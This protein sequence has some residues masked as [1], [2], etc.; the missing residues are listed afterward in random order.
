[1]EGTLKRGTEGLR[2]KWNELESVRE[3]VENRLSLSVSSF[4]SLT[5]RF[6]PICIQDLEETFLCSSKG[7]ALNRRRP[8]H[9]E[10]VSL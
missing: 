9:S 7:I 3:N 8:M 2:R 5:W 10:L 1:M 6:T 4:L